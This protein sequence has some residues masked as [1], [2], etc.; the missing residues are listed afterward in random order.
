MMKHKRIPKPPVGAKLRE[1]R[2]D[3]IFTVVAD[4]GHLVEIAHGDDPT[5]FRIGPEMIAIGRFEP[6]EPEEES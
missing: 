3:E 2:T 5:G 1:T 4:H 6:V